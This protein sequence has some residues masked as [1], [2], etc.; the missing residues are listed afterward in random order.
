MLSG[1]ELVKQLNLLTQSK[2]AG[3]FGKNL[4]N[5]MMDVVDALLSRK[6]IDKKQH[7]TLYEKYIN[8]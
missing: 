6:I 8:F 4:D 3:N 7:K 5:N 1:D 2:M